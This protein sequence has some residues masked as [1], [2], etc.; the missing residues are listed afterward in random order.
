MPPAGSTVGGGLHVTP[1]NAT[2][3]QREKSSE[4]HSELL[5]AGVAGV[6]RATG[7]GVTHMKA[8]FDRESLTLIIRFS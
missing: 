5:S 6:R 8:V 2:R 1:L 4:A 7:R 3:C